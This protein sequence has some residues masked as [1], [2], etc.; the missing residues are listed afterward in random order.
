MNKQQEQTSLSSGVN[1]YFVYLLPFQKPKQTNIF[2]K[3]KLRV[4]WL[5]TM[6]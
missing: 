3:G 4:M 5:K 1:V 2:C 6:Q